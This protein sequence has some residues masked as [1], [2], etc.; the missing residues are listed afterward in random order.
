MQA[1]VPRL[2]QIRNRDE[3]R[4]VAALSSF[5]FLTAGAYV[6]CRTVADTLFLDHVG[7]ENLPTAHLVATFTVVILTTLIHR[8]HL[9]LLGV[10]ATQ[11]ILAAAT[12]V[13]PLLPTAWYE[14]LPGLAYGFLYLLAQLHGTAGMVLITLLLQRCFHGDEPT[15]VF[16]VVGAGAT[17][18]AMAFGG[19]ILTFVSTVGPLNLLLLVVALDVLAILPPSLLSSDL[20]NKPPPAAQDKRP[21]SQR[22][23]NHKPPIVH[24]IIVLVMAKVAVLTLIEF[25]WKVAVFDAH[26]GEDANV[27]QY[28]AGYYLSVNLITGFIQLLLAGRFLQRFGITSALLVL[29]SSLVLGS[30]AV[31]TVYTTYIP[32]WLATILKGSESFRRGVND[33]ALQL[34]FKSLPRGERQAAVTQTHGIA[35]PLS[36]LAAAL[37]LQSVAA[38]ISPHD[39]SWVI[40][41]LSV[42]WFGAVSYVRKLLVADTRL[43][44]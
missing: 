5:A 26:I 10:L 37:L 4:R 6:T 31:I 36:E 7:P 25:Q 11:I 34:L 35:K 24:A 32:L 28:F 27:A 9:K 17:I 44:A 12:A 13:L 20:S 42:F 2:L 15:R 38:T 8:V 3:F 40:L 29:P 23:V 16:A 39:I 43:P 30:V 21:I 22:Q 33:P 18:A 14:H 41:L 1:L 19:V